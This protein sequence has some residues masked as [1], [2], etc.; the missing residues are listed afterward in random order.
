VR[1][2]ATEFAEGIARCALREPAHRA[3]QSDARSPCG[4]QTRGDSGGDLPEE[5]DPTRA[6]GRIGDLTLGPA[7]E[8]GSCD[9]HGGG[10]HRLAAHVFQPARERCNQACAETLILG[11]CLLLR[12]DHRAQ[13]GGKIGARLVILDR[14]E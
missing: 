3:A 10:F 13:L 6:H 7:H 5:I 12:R 9:A 1:R 2:Q 11:L 8:I 14:G 4:E